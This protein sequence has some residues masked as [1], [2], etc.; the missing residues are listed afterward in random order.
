MITKYSFISI[1]HGGEVVSLISPILC[2]RHWRTPYL[3]FFLYRKTG[4]ELL[5]H[6]FPPTQHTLYL[7]KVNSHN[8][9]I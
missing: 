1:F 4:G 8:V 7:V 2:L 5:L 9:I 3:F 6:Y